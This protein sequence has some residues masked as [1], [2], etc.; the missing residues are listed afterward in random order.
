M[1]EIAT[2]QCTNLKCRYIIRVSREFP[3]WHPDTPLSVRTLS[4]SPSAAPYVL[5]YRSEL[6]CHRCRKIVEHT[7]DTTCALCGATD[8]R[9]EQTGKS[10]AQCTQ[11][12]F[13]MTKLTVY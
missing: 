5:K 12:F 10:C 4:K 8:V 13:E 2:Y 11:G 9:E 1:A 7:G 3:V 6:F